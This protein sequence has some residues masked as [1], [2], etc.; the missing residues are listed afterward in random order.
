MCECSHKGKGGDGEEQEASRSLPWSP[1]LQIVIHVPWLEA[2]F[3][4]LLRPRPETGEVQLG[5]G[6]AITVP[7]HQLAALLSR[8]AEA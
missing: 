4:S 1:L 3:T 6:A 8:Q 2:S 5:G 7:P